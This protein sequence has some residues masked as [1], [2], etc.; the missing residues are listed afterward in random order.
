[1]NGMATTTKAKEIQAEIATR[2]CVCFIEQRRPIRRHDILI[3]FESPDVLDEME[4]R[5]LAGVNPNSREYLPTAG[6]FALLGDQHEL[7]VQAGSAFVK[8][9]PILWNLYRRDAGEVHYQTADLH[10]SASEFMEE[11]ITQQVIDLGVYLCEQ[12]GIFSTWKHS[13]DRTTIETFK[14]AES[15][16]TMRDPM[17]WWA[18]RVRRAREGYSQE[19]APTT[20]PVRLPAIG[21]H[22]QDTFWSLLN[23]AVVGR[24]MPRFKAGHY[25]DAVE[26]A[27]KVV[28]QQVR[29]KTGL[30]EDGA[31]LM[32]KAFSPKNPHLVFDDPMPGTK[33]SLQQGYM[34]IFAG[35]MTGVRNPKAHGLVDIDARRCIH[36]LFLAS[37]LAD[38]IAEA[39]HVPPAEEVPVSIVPKPNPAL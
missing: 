15:V 36:F 27:L 28:S 12:F 26:A 31:S 22:G 14:I 39:G 6:T 5:G 30:T 8:T 1:M 33:D 20:E 18:E 4:M 23:P 35:T 10:E 29:D 19:L 32:L 34:Q 25:A 11:S 17:P 37:L 21:D 3:E 13:A 7:Y 38:K 9:I 16:I 24:A 2:L